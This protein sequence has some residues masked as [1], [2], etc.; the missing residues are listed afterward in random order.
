[1]LDHISMYSNTFVNFIVSLLIV[2]QFLL[3]YYALFAQ[4]YQIGSSLPHDSIQVNILILYFFVILLKF[5]ELLSQ[6]EDLVFSLLQSLFVQLYLI[7]QSSINFIELH[8]GASQLFCFL[9]N[10]LDFFKKLWFDLSDIFKK[11]LDLEPH[12]F[13]GDE[14]VDVV[15]LSVPKS[16]IF[17]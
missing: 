3:K 16:E 9:E 13:I 12:L 1:M 5:F 4:F 6:F 2:W 14:F 7:R 11:C 10:I 15:H 17:L 8:T